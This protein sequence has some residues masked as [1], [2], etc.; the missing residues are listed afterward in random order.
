V[1]RFAK[2]PALIFLLSDFLTQETAQLA[3]ALTRLHRRYEVVALHLTDPLETTFPG[4]NVRIR[5]RDLETQRVQTYSLTQ[6]HRQR[7]T[8]HAQA[9]HAI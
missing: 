9:Q 2:P 1:E 4:G 5:L 8:A 7:L 6:K 3:R